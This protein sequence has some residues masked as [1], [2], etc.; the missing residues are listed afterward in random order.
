MENVIQKLVN[1]SAKV[2]GLDPY[3]IKFLKLKK[4]N[5]KKLILIM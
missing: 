3:V 2:H 1:V 5:L 4:L